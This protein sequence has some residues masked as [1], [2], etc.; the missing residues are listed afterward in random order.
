MAR[1]IIQLFCFILPWFM[2]R[3][4]L[5]SIG[6]KL[7]PESRIGYTIIYSKEVI[8][9]RRAYI[10]HLNLIKGL[11]VLHLEE[12]ARIGNLNW[13][14]SMGTKLADS[15][16]W[17]APPHCAL[18]LGKSASITHQHLIDCSDNVAI[19]KYATVAGWRTQILTHSIDIEIGR[20]SVA[21]VHIGEFAFLGSGC[22][23]LKGSKLP[24]KSVLAAGA[25]LARKYEEEHTLYA[26]LPA[27]AVKQLSPDAKYFNRTESRVW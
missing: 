26:G 21:P 23:V 15:V 5:N 6:M 8:L 20:Q 18:Y 24:N 14:S 11:Q 17:T 19:G 12:E 1:I 9:E 3:A 2:R 22:I 27:Q 10:G 4:I 7:H 25:L 13:I 16:A